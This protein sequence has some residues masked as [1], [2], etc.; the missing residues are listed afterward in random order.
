MTV[1]STLLLA[2]V[3]VWAKLATFLCHA[4]LLTGWTRQWWTFGVSVDSRAGE[5][6][7]VAVALDALLR[8]DPFAV[9]VNYAMQVT[10]S[11][12]NRA[13]LSLRNDG[14]LASDRSAERRFTLDLTVKT[15][16]MLTTL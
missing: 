11:E 16:T 15:G 14:I 13:T 3:H 12:T 4:E 9:I 8:R 1:R 5:A 6:T 7:V 2:F 10:L